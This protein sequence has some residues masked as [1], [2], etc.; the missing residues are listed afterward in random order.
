M[1][2]RSTN[3]GRARRRRADGAV[4][5]DEAYLQEMSAEESEAEA[6]DAEA[7]GEAAGE[8]DERYAAPGTPE[9]PEGGEDAPCISSFR[10]S[11]FGMRGK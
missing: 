4:Q 5:A 11:A 10:Q 3:R 1:A 2:R 9:V 6:A 7:G 8:A